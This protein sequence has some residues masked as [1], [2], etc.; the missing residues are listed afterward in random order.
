MGIPGGFQ[1]NGGVLLAERCKLD[2]RLLDEGPRPRRH[3]LNE[4][5]PTYAHFER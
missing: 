2:P 3:N 5:S 1:Q 4:M